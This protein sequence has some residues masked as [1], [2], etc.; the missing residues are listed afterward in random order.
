MN[1][2]KIFYKSFKFFNDTINSVLPFIVFY[3]IIIILINYLFG[4]SELSEENLLLYS[5]SIESII[6]LLITYFINLLYSI[7]IIQ[8]IFSKIKSSRR[9]NILNWQS[10]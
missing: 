2:D 4:S 1:I 7:L 9:K 5:I 8:F 3:S 6:S 10:R